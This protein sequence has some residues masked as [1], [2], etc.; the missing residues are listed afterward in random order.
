[1]IDI[2]DREFALHTDHSSYLMRVD[3]SGYLRHDY[4]GVRLPNGTCFQADTR[5]P[6]PDAGCWPNLI[7]ME[8]AGT[9]H[10][11]NRLPAVEVRYANGSETVDLRYV[12]SKVFTGCHAHK[13][14]PGF[15]GNDDV[16]TL[17]VTL[18]D[19]L[20]LRITLTYTVYEKEDMITRAARIENQAKMPFTVLKASSL[21]M[22]LG[23][24]MLDFITL[25]GAWAHENQLERAA[26]RYG[27]QSVGSWMGIPS[28]FHNPAAVLCSQDTS[29]D[30]GECWGFALVYSGNFEISVHRSWENV[31]LVMGIHPRNFCW[32]LRPG[33][34]FQTPEVAMIY[35][36]SGLG[37]LSRLFHRSIH[38]RLLPPCR[39]GAAAPRPILVNSW[40]ASYFNFNEERLLALARAAKS[41]GVD[42]LVV[43]DGWFGHRDAETSSLGDWTADRRKLPNGLPGLCDKLA[44]MGV[45]LGIWM[46]PE[47]ISPNSDLYRAHPDWAL[48]VPGRTP[49]QIRNQYVLDFSRQDVVDGIWEQIR[50]VL[51]GCRIQYVKWDM[52]RSL[53]DVYSIVLP[54]ERQGEIMHRYV[55]GVYELQRRIKE[56][57]PHVLLENC[58]AGGARFDCGMLYYSP[59]IWLSDD[60]DALERVGIQLG[61]SLIYPLCVMGAH[62]SSVPNHITWRNASI[63]ARMACALSGSFGYELDLASM[64]H[65]EL[66]TLLAW[67]Q[68]YR[69]HGTLIRDGELYRLNQEPSG[70]A[71]M[72][73]SQDGDEAAVFAVGSGCLGNGAASPRLR[74]KGLMS[75]VL[76]AIPGD[77]CRLGTELMTLGLPMPACSGDLP[78]AV[79]YLSKKEAN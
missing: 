10:G 52:N 17:A 27:I 50:N 7:P 44:E 60:T 69:A 75:D 40:E 55:L 70:G 6:H 2:K 23:K 76:Y 42:T 4:Y 19:A 77:E 11:D 30:A 38:D 56:H 67:S 51:S 53:T 41:A 12:D 22:D 59:Q 61:A 31:R 73:V 37:S 62:Y 25:N 71:W 64:K 43:D 58:A 20:G 78:G 26:L 16:Q 21:C 18:E 68:W 48:A 9:G 5:A 49:L 79:I 8:Y 57:F 54:A 47:A 35:S 28:H 15:R 33:D 45:A 14:L 3:A 34:A 63:E 66:E 46:E 65:E 32:H 13:G 74:L 29:E 36:G 1:M 72:V 24:H 39:R